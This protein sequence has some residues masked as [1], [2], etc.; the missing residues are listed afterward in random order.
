MGRMATG[1]GDR[2]RPGGDR[3]PSMLLSDRGPS[4][5]LGRGVVDDS[6]ESKSLAHARLLNDVS[7][8]RDH[9][10]ERF[11]CRKGA[12]RARR[13]AMF[14]A[15]ARSK[16]DVPMHGRDGASELSQVKRR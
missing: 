7:T 2:G 10:L 12:K 5:L 1:E 11:K 3:G 15:R 14:H 4:M 8:V 16:G 6:S 9:R 13:K